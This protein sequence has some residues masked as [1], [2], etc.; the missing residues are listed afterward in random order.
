MWQAGGTPNP[1]LCMGV[2][3]CKCVCLCVLCTL[4]QGTQVGRGRQIAGPGSLCATSTQPGQKRK[5]SSAGDEGKLAPPSLDAAPGRVGTGSLTSVGLTM[6][7][8]EGLRRG[9][10]GSQAGGEGQV[11][12]PH[13]AGRKEW[14]SQWPQSRLWERRLAWDGRGACVKWKGKTTE[15]G[16]VGESLRGWGGGLCQGQ[17]RIEGD[18]PHSVWDATLDWGREQRM[19]AFT[20]SRD[21]EL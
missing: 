10:E 21:P 20:R 3:M 7:K 5:V 8:Q 14:C 13:L 18:Q 12:E 17:S 19:N 16:L 15:P 9:H 11:A 6:S 1:Q 4:M 2:H